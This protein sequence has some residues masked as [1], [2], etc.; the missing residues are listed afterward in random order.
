[1]LHHERFTEKKNKRAR[2]QWIICK[3]FNAWTCKLSVMCLV[4]NQA[5]YML[6]SLQTCCTTN[7]NNSRLPSA[8]MKPEEK[9]RNTKFTYTH[10]WTIM[11]SQL[12]IKKFRIHSINRLRVVQCSG[13]F[14]FCLSIVF[15]IL[16]ALFVVGSSFVN[17]FTGTETTNM[18]YFTGLEI[19][20]LIIH[21]STFNGCYEVT[22][23]H[24][25]SF[26]LHAKIFD[27]IYLAW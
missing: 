22:Q 24:C 21:I 23:A 6:F 2:K 27:E 16:L 14:F 1:M 25:V 8:K 9:K 13:I 26:S 4:T 7:D 17:E 10:N 18:F 15:C 12:T 11:T 20:R 3:A 5:F 19:V